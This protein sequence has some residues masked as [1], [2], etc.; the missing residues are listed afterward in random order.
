[1]FSLR[2]RGFALFLAALAVR[3]LVGWRLGHFSNPTMWEPE[4]IAQNILSGKGFVIEHLGIDY[5][6]Y[7]LPLYPVFCAIVY[8]LTGKSQV[9][10]LLLTC[11]ISAGACLQVRAIGKR[12]F[13]DTAIAQT[14]GWLTALHPGL[15][16]Y[17]SLLHPLTLDGVTYLWVTWGWM[18]LFEKPT[19]RLAL[20]IGL[21]S[22]LALLS[23]GTIVIFLFFASALFLWK[24]PL[25]KRKAL[26]LLATAAITAAIAVSP[27]LIRNTVVFHRFPLFIT[28]GS[29]SLW[30]G[31]NPLSNGTAHLANGSQIIH[32]LTPKMRQELARRDELGQSDLFKE[33]A[34]RFIRSKPAAALQLLWRKWIGFWW[35][36][37]NAG[38]YYPS[39][40]L[41]AYRWYYTTILT[42][43]LWALWQLRRRWTE[44]PLLLLVGFALSVGL[45]QSLHYVEGR[46]RWTVE[47]VLLLFA[48]AAPR[49]LR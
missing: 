15:I 36:A 10:L 46:H 45:F 2:S 43:S 3:I 25:S 41:Q 20:W 38:L 14:A 11:L 31:N 1:M 4:W 28:S 32:S 6:A 21:G 30:E 39:A 19:T 26:S 7:L 23:R 40:Y 42:A 18:C 35:F 33:E 13:P 24:G 27:W 37:P 44:L 8:A 48:A 29:Q 5:R 17:A 9:A 47:P 22:G 12:L 16:Y 34:W 49:R